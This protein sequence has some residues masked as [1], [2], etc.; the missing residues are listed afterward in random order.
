MLVCCYKVTFHIIVFLLQTDNG[1]FALV[2]G[3]NL[4]VWD[5]GSYVSNDFPVL[6]SDISEIVIWLPTDVIAVTVAT[7][8]DGTP[9]VVSSSSS[10]PPNL[11]A[12]TGPRDT[13]TLTGTTSL[14]VN[15]VDDL[16][17]CYV[18]DDCLIGCKHE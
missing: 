17:F 3:G 2:E 10:S 14:P 7:A 5:Y 16:Y 1:R 13:V 8:P 4:Y 12:S 15:N 11:R 9:F 6:F 18:E